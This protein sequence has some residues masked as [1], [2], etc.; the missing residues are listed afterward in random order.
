MFTA[1]LGLLVTSIVASTEA[2]NKPPASFQN[3]FGIRETDSRNSGGN[4]EEQLLGKL[5]EIVEA[6]QF[7]NQQVSFYE[8][9]RIF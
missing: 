4:S 1:V 8:W 7:G 3:T 2:K 5:G 9:F 6:L